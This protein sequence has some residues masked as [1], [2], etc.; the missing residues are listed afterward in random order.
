MKQQEHL[1]AQIEWTDRRNDVVAAFKK[2]RANHS[3]KK[4]STGTKFFVWFKDHC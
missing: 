1:L 3:A 4:S 2:Y